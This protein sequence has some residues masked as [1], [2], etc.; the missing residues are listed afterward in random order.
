M[1]N[2][3]TSLIPSKRHAETD[4][5]P[6]SHRRTRGVRVDY[7]Y[8]NDPFP[9]EIEAGIATVEKEEAFAV[10]P[11]E[12]CR[13]LQQAKA[14]P[15]WPEWEDAI[16]SELTQLKQMGTWKLVDKPRNIIPIS[17]K[18][19]FTKKRDKDGNLLKYKARLVA[20]GYAQRPGY[21]YVDTHSPVVRLETIRAILAIAPSRKLH[22]HQLDI[23]GAYLNGTLKE[24]VYMKQPEGYEDG[25]GRVCQLIKTLYG[26]KQAGREWNL[27]L[28][29]KMQKRGYSRLR[30]DP[31]VYIYR[32]DDDFVAITVWV[33]DMLLFSTTIEL[34]MKAINDIESEWQITDLGT[35][36]KIVGIEL[37]ITPD[38]IFISSSSYINSILQKEMLDRCNAVSTPLDPNVTLEAN[39]EENISDR[40]NPYARLL[41]ELQ[42]VANATRPDIAYA[43]NRLAAYTANPSLQHHT[44]LKRILRYLSGTKT[45][46]ITYK[47][48]GEKVDFFSGY[49]DAAYANADE[50]RSTTGYVFLAG[51]GAIS[52]NS[53]KQ[54]SNALSSTQAE[55]VALSEA[56]REACWLRN[57]YT[58]LGLLR[59]DIPTRIWGD[60]DGSIAMARNPQFHKRTK[61]ISIRWHWIRELV[62]DGTIDI[63][64][65]R[66]PEQ[67]ADVLTKA[68]PRAKHRQHV[69]E[70]GLTP[71]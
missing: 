20:K 63:E 55:Y 14:S 6:R 64:T 18:F 9:D 41:G 31:C 60:N 10:L 23:K 52:W 56:A 11:N 47:A 4:A 54:I 70:M 53:K 58:E 34:K 19:V 38:S 7:R 57:L 43:V 40:S 3:T 12:E 45:H 49:A 35:P 25:T 1:G 16:L 66:D 2:Q 37:T 59:D 65:C 69:Q 33:D 67:T 68:L 26:L 29:R 30:S 36:T 22:I 13:N 46:G 71:A 62:R 15:E 42:Y 21:D 48:V 32:V 50:G 39:P 17:N 24:K 8:L 5:D 28:D 27:E 61:H 51:G 44:A